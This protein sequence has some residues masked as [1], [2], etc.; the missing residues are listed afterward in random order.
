VEFVVAGLALLLAVAALLAAGFVWVTL[1]ARIRELELQG[2]GSVA[3]PTSSN[4]HNAS[5]DEL[6]PCSPRVRL[7]AKTLGRKDEAIQVY[8][9]ENKVSHEA[10]TAAI[11]KLMAE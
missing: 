9:N 7:L 5:P 4:D 3:A 8:Q 1:S 11:E 10:A 2:G 6:P